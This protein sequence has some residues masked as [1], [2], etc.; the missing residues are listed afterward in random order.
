MTKPNKLK[1]IDINGN[2][3]N[4]AEELRDALLEAKAPIFIDGK[5]LSLRMANGTM[6]PLMPIRRMQYWISNYVKFTKEGK[7]VNAPGNL[8][9][10]FSNAAVDLSWFDH[11]QEE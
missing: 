1:T 10:V 5:N 6:L 8:L 3:A 4:S 7:P 9:R 2:L 11:L